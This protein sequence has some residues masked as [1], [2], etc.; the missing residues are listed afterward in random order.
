MTTQYPFEIAEKSVQIA[1]TKSEKKIINSKGEQYKKKYNKIPEE[2]NRSKCFDKFCLGC[3]KCCDYSLNKI[4]IF[5]ACEKCGNNK[6]YK[7]CGNC[8]KC[9]KNKSKNAYFIEEELINDKLEV[10]YYSIFR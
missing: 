6:K 1:P 8:C 7:F 9:Q 3:K 2:K 4:R 5:E 10:I